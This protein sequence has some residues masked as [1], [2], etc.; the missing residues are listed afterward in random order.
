LSKDL[1]LSVAGIE[2]VRHR[3]IEERKK[4]AADSLSKINSGHA[5][6]MLIKVMLL[7]LLKKNEI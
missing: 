1:L 3:R 2:A 7:L 6:P 4:I 5:I